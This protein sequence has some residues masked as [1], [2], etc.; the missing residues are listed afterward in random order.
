[1]SLMERIKS[2]FAGGSSDEAHDHAGHDDAGH[3]HSHEPIAPPTSPADPAGM[4]TSDTPSEDSE[5]R[6]S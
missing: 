1:M 5:N 3:D 6:L 4:P 2:M